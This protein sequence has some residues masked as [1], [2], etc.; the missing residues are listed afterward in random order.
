M[1]DDGSTE[2]LGVRRDPVMHKRT[3][4]AATSAVMALFLV[5]VPAFADSESVGTPISI[6]WRLVAILLVVA[7]LLFAAAL[8]LGDRAD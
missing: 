4:A 3:I 1:C 8:G 2:A 5:A 7:L 6:D